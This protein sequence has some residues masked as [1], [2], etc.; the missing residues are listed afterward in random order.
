M[1]R[2]LVEYIIAGVDYFEAEAR[3]LRRGVMRLG[4]G[5]MLLLAAGLLLVGG[6]GLL[7]AGLYL[8]LAIY[9][10]PYAA[11]GIDG[12][13]V[14]VLAGALIWRARAVTD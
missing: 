9:L 3:A 5:L 11:A 2:A 10:P 4:L 1:L 12:A 13:V 8:L 14:L 7:A 6:I